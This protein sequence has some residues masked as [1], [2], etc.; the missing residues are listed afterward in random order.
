MNHTQAAAI[1]ADS[2]RPSP[3][4]LDRLMTAAEV[5]ST[6]RICRATLYS[7]IR[8]GGIPEPVKFGSASRWRAS[9]IARIMA[10]RTH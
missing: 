4:D 1:L 3:F 9:D 5:M 6:L 10:G 8:K 2:R 7:Q